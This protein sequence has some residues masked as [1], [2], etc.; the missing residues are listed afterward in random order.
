MGLSTY[1][2]SPYAMAG[3]ADDWEQG[4]QTCVNVLCAY[5]RLPY[6]PDPGPGAAAGSCAATAGADD[7][8]PGIPAAASGSGRAR[9]SGV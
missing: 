5:L 1:F 4:R 9:Q 8:V 2:Y 6:A 7:R 3:L